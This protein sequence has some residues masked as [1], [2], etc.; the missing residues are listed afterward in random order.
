MKTLPDAREDE[1]CEM[2][3]NSPD[4]WRP[5]EAGKRSAQIFEARAA[6]K[7]ANSA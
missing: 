4:Y 2:T 1:T 7:L 6:K 5:R 3:L